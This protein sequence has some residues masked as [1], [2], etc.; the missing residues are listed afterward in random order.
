MAIS[1][2]QPAKN[3]NLLTVSANTTGGFRSL[4]NSGTPNR[5]KRN[6]L[7]PTSG[8]KPSSNFLT[9]DR[10]SRTMESSGGPKPRNLSASP[11][12]T[13]HDWGNTEIL[14]KPHKLS[15]E[16]KKPVSSAVYTIEGQHLA[17]MW[18]QYEGIWFD[19]HSQGMGPI[20]GDFPTPKPGRSA[21]ANPGNFTQSSLTSTTK[22][23]QVISAKWKKPKFLGDDEDDLIL[24]S[25]CK[26]KKKKGVYL[27]CLHIF[28]KEC[29]YD[30]FKKHLDEKKVPVRCMATNCK[31]EIQRNEL[32]KIAHNSEEI[33]AFYDMNVTKFVEKRPHQLVQCYSPGCGYVCDLAKAKDKNVLV[34]PRCKKN[35]CMRCH[36][37]AH[38]GECEEGKDSK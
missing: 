21:S 23:K 5:D 29:L 6:L 1:K 9:P 27:G 34:C 19:I 17:G 22:T 2:K 24:C 25:K 36:Q 37:L 16:G 3:P 10:S 31:Y 4:S 26:K 14:P 35:Y 15:P 8:T 38:T 11:S 7:T 18:Q 28:C 20:L 33:K 32:V 30:Q 12:A 13:K